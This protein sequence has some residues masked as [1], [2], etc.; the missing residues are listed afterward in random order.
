MNSAEQQCP[1]C[2]TMAPLDMALCPR[3]GMA[4]SAPSKLIYGCGL[5][6]FQ[7]CL[8]FLPFAFALAG[9]FF[10]LMGVADNHPILSVIG[11]GFGWFCLTAISLRAFF[12]VGKFRR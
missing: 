8:G 2:G 9:V 11:T 7:A 5:L 12:W 3:C 1:N 10:T 4:L 6:L